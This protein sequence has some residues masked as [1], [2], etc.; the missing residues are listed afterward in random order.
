MKKPPRLVTRIM[1]SLHLFA[2]RSGGRHSYGHSLNSNPSG[3][4]VIATSSPHELHHQFTSTVD[5]VGSRRCK[6]RG[7]F[8]ASAY[9][10]FMI[11]T[12]ADGDRI[13]PQ[14]RT[15]PPARGRPVR[16]TTP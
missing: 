5:L 3:R 12:A 10:L 2:L 1:R 9:M 7:Q 4:S 8:G 11:A 13:C 16:I 14:Q 15:G 6:Q